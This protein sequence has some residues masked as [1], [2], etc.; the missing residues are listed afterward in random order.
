MTEEQLEVEAGRDRVCAD[1]G[2]T[3]RLT[4]SELVWFEIKIAQQPDFRLPRRCADCRR[5][6]REWRRHQ[7]ER[8]L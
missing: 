6:K 1:C 5:L 2:N 7:E 4:A 8:R 3:Y